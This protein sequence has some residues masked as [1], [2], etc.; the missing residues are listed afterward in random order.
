MG[1]PPVDIR[2]VA[3]VHIKSLTM[4]NVV[5]KRFLLV[6]TTDAVPLLTFAKWLS[7]EFSSKGYSIPLTPA[8]SFLLKISTI[9]DK[10]ITFLLPYLEKF[11]KFDNSRYLTT[12]GIQPYDPKKSLVEM[13]YSMIEKGLIPKKF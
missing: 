4:D 9:F 13:T 8:P 6:S 12:F 7:D 10:R 3:S 11:P 2:D 1:L 5:G